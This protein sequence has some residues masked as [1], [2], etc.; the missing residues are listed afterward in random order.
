MNGEGPNLIERFNQAVR[1]IVTLG[2]TT[3][4]LYGFWADKISGEV[5]TSVFAGVIGYWFASRDARM[6][7]ADQ[8]TMTT[9]KGDTTVVAGPSPKPAGG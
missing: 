5:F 8:T 6:R 1:S 4:F 3:G 9:T 2:L 7:A